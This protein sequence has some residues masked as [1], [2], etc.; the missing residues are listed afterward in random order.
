[1]KFFYEDEE[2]G[3]IYSVKNGA[4]GQL[5]SKRAKSTRNVNLL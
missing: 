1:M 5:Q 3:Y 2:C 4:T